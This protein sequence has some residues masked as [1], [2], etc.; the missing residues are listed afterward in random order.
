[1]P[2][3]GGAG[4]TIKRTLVA[5]ASSCAW[6]RLRVQAAT[7][8]TQTVLS[9]AGGKNCGQGN[10]SQAFRV[11]TAV[12]HVYGAGKSGKERNTKKTTNEKKK[13]DYEKRREA[14]IQTQRGRK[15][16]KNQWKEVREV[17]RKETIRNQEEISK[18]K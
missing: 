17:E 3:T 16:Q 1:M 12:E 13:A 11:C 9:L 5:V 10:H 18:M 4:V 15:R 8:W 7:R 6:R 2:P 14:R